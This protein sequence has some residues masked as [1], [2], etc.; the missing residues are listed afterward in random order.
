MDPA[1]FV[2]DLKTALTLLGLGNLIAGFLL[3]LSRRG[4]YTDQAAMSFMLAKAL[5]GAGFLMLASAGRSV[6]A[7]GEVAA[8]SLCLG[9]LAF[10]SLAIMAV[11]GIRFPA[12]T[13]LAGLGAAAAFCVFLLPD[14]Q[15]L[16]AGYAS[17]F[18][19]LALLPGLFA[20][21]FSSRT[22]Q[23]DVGLGFVY[24]LIIAAFSLRAWLNLTTPWETGEMLGVPAPTAWRGL[25][26]LLFLTGTVGITL[27]FQDRADTQAEHNVTFDA[28]TGAFT[29][30]FF[31]E[32]TQRALNLATRRKSKLAIL[33]FDVD[34]FTAV[35][36]SLGY[37]KGDMVLSSLAQTLR[38]TLRPYDIL[39]RTGGGGFGAVLPDASEEDAARAAE[40]VRAAL[41]EFAKEAPGVPGFTVSVGVCSEVPE[42]GATAEAFLACG[43]KAL[44]KAKQLGR[45]R[46]EYYRDGEPGQAA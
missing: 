12:A 46:V 8:N 43:E 16:A 38:K 41:A 14:T 21:Y 18:T 42:P 39:G 23:Y 24:L 1:N 35:N 10:E 19:A 28:L 4:K 7:P 11:K 3:W 37:R 30:N 44:V 6:G 31:L 45:D 27:L 36:D 9:G 13:G 40:R 22:T 20:L 29:R 33:L 26:F 5:Q 2:L 25:R 34:R 32:E 15:P 17:G